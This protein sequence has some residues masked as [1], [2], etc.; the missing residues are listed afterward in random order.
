MGKRETVGEAAARVAQQEQNPEEPPE[1]IRLFWMVFES[2]SKNPSP[3]YWAQCLG[4][5]D[6]CHDVHVLYERANTITTRPK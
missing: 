3:P 6:D 4:N 2:P 1:T 5:G